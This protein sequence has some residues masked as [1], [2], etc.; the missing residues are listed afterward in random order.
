L[1]LVLI[2]SKAF[3]DYSTSGLE[4]PLS[5]LLLAGVV[6]AFYRRKSRRRLLW[7]SLLTGLL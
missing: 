2:F 7:T 5:F 1:V 3:I 4:N 6:T